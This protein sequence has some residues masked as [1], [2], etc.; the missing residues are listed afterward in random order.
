VWP[1]KADRSFLA[2]LA[3]LLPAGRRR[4]LVATP[5]TLLGWHRDLVRRKWSQPSRGPGRPAVEQRVRELVLRP[6]RENPRWGYPRI[7][8]E[9]G[10]LAIKVSSST[11]RRI[12]LAAGLEPA[13]RRIGL[14]WQQ[15]LR[16]QAA[17]IIAWQL[18]HGR[19]A[20]PAPL[21]RASVH[22]TCNT[23]RSSR[24]LHD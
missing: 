14:S 8:G 20:D 18:L 13:P 19:D 11:A 21:L 16:Q 15:F 1:R 24:W 2:A 5:Q 6:A 22:R 17:S 3:R 10:K 12:L 23:S 7:A 4:G 9:L